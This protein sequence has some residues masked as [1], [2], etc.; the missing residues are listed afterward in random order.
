MQD[1]NAVLVISDNK[2]MVVFLRKTVNEKNIANAIF[3]Y[4][5]SPK[6]EVNDLEW[7][8]E[9]DVKEE[10]ESIAQEFDLVLSL[11][12]KQL[13]P[14]YLVRKSRCINIHPGLNPYN[15]GFYPQVFSI[16]NDL[17]CGATI[18][19]ID[20]KVDN[21]PVIAQREV[22]I[23]TLDTSLT[24]Y[25]RITEAEK[26]LIVENIENLVSGS[27]ETYSTP[28]GN[29]NLK[30]DFEKLCEIDLDDANTFEN[31]IKKLRALTHGDYKNAYFKD[32]N[33]KKVYIR[34]DLCRD[35]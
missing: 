29:L 26:K 28:E 19:E 15:R 33:G 11:H 4:A 31:H 18:H 20:E 27:Y 8:R 7:I 25:Q 10:K 30:S 21:G 16:I 23:N 1:M 13:F 22:D 14:E 34:I 9:I 32:K 35:E 17:P 3:S 2:E 12:C 6:S 24:A 5:C